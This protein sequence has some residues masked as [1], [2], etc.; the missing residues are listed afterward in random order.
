M[1]PATF[2]PTPADLGKEIFAV[3]SIDAGTMHNGQNQY[4]LDEAMLESIPEPASLLL[5][6]PCLGLAS[7]RR[8]L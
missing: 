6:L 5:L 8:S 7:L 4:V 2:N 3:V 1:G